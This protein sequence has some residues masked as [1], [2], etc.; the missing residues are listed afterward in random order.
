MKRSDAF[1]I[2]VETLLNNTELTYVSEEL[3]DIL[4][5]KLEAV[6]MEP[7]YRE[8]EKVIPELG[9][10]TFSENTWESEDEN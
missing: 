7:P 3:C 4:L 10:V 8:Y 1:E 5:V 9:A 6:G 2:I